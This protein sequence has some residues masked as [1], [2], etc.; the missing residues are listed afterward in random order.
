MS[1]VRYFEI[2]GLRLGPFT[3]E[4]DE[5]KAVNEHILAAVAEGF[6]PIH[7]TRLVEVDGVDRACD[8]CDLRWTVGEGPSEHY[9]WAGPYWSQQTIRSPLTGELLIG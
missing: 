1:E 2:G 7:V 9:P 4:D 5:R 3:N 8:Q 6:C